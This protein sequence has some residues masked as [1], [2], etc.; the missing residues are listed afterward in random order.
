MCLQDIVK[1]QAAIEIGYDLAVGS[2]LPSTGFSL[3]AIGLEDEVVRIKVFNYNGVCTIDT[4]EKNLRKTNALDTLKAHL[5]EIKEDTRLTREE[6]KT[7]LYL[8]TKSLGRNILTFK[9]LVS[10][11]QSPELES[12]LEAFRCLQL[13]NIENLILHNQV[14]KQTII[15]DLAASEDEKTRLGLLKYVSDYEVQMLSLLEKK[16][17]T[18]PDGQTRLDL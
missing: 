14:V 1:N 9:E 4:T 5:Q 7:L 3:I 12:E 15:H 2:P 13:N 10:I 16:P 18:E 6:E 11:L 17:L 8:T